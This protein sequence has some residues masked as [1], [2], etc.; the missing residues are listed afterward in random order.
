MPTNQEPCAAHRRRSISVPVSTLAHMHAS[1]RETCDLPREPLS[2]DHSGGAA[3]YSVIV[4]IWTA[5]RRSTPAATRNCAVT[6]RD[7]HGKNCS[8][9]RQTVVIQTVVCDVPPLFCSNM[10]VC[11]H[12]FWRSTY[13]FKI[14]ESNVF[15]VSKMPPFAADVSW[16][17]SVGFFFQPPHHEFRQN[18]RHVASSIALTRIPL[19]GVETNF[20]L[21][22]KLGTWHCW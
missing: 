17:S 15:L 13:A 12:V 11:S 10:Q 18:T 8:A 20:T 16:G 7:E 22:K 6:F 9:F 3:A 21:H 5:C 19:R 1:L 4:V 2:G 14:R